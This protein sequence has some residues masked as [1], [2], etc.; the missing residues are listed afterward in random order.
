MKT[1]LALGSALILSLLSLTSP[2]LADGYA[3]K[4]GDTLKV[5]VLEDA[6]LNRSVLVG[7]DGRI[8]FPQ[9]GTIK[10]SGQ[11]VDA[12]AGIIAAKIAPNFAKAPNVF[13]ALEQ[14]AAVPPPGAVVASS[15][16]IYVLGEA[17]KTGKLDL[18]PG[19]TVLQAFAQM[20]GFTKFAAT[21]RIQ[22]RR[23][24]KGGAATTYLLN[25]DAIEAGSSPNGTVT[26]KAGDVIVVPQRHLF[27]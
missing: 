27:E 14:L 23:T 19:S 21:K 16:G 8:S 20:G 1:L 7:P 22:L 6:S 13:V 24:D 9:A 5:E 15:S 3:I 4:P 11:P 10:V 26:L 25:Y 17:N 18:T 12:I 2:A